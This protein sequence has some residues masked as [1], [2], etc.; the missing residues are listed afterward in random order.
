[1]NIWSNFH[2]EFLSMNFIM[3][4][5]SHHRNNIDVNLIGGYISALEAFGKKITGTS[6]I[7][8]NFEE[9]VFH[10]YRE[11]EDSSLLYLIVA[12]RDDKDDSI[13]IK[14]QRIADLFYNKYSKVLEGFNGIVNPFYTFGDT[15]VEMKIADTDCGNGPECSKCPNAKKSSKIPEYIGKLHKKLVPKEN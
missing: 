14:I 10:F 13:N 1:M 11:P 12:N 7:S 9:L 4:D 8:I 15:L 6:I 3:D 2:K 5:L